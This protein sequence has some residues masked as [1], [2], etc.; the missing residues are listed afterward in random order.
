MAT[1]ERLDGN[2]VAA[3]VRV[4]IVDDDPLVRA[5]LTMM[6]REFEDLEVVGAIGDGREVAAAV[7]Q[8]RP[9]VVLMDIRMPTVDGLTATAT[10][11][12]RRDPPEVIVLTTFDTDEH[13]RRA[14]RVGASG[15]LL[16]HAPPVQIANAIRRVAAGEPMFS[17]EVLRRVLAFAAEP[18]PDP[19]RQRAIEMLNRL[20]PTERAVADLVGEGRTNNEIGVELRMSTATVKALMTRIM[21]KLELNNRVQVALLVHEATR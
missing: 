20:S 5:G 18:E 10:L 9:E 7:N 21:A 19:R 13:I 8:F 6:L 1:I 16:K 14:L 11:R 15:F 17:P 4:L 3:A 2:P 12:A